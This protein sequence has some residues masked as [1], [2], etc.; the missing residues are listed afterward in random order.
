MEKRIIAFDIG[1]RRV[2]IAI[3]DPFNSYAMPC[4]TYFRSGS[5]AEDAARLA[6]LAEREGAGSIVCGL[7]LNADS[8]ESE[9]TLKTRRFARV[10]RE[11]TKLPVFFEDERYTTQS[12]RCDLVGMGV[13]ARQ[14]KKKKTIDSLAAAYILESYLSK[15]KR[16]TETMSLKEENNYYEDDE[17]IVELVDE[18]G[19]KSRYEHI[20]TIEYKGEWYCFFTPEAAEDESEDEE[21]EV[22]ALHLVGE[23]DDE[24]LETI[25]DEALL[26]EVFTEFARQYEEDED[27]EEDNN[28]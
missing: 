15:I 3:S 9:Q 8:T 24:H 17:N 4:E 10:L 19:N 21:E 20:G 5:V 22:M 1:D 6:E 27:D 7:P 12:A 26:D 25:E 2:G 16:E 11:S 13:S 14:D 28:G 23:E 18:E